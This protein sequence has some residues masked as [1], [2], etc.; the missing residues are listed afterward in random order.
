MAHLKKNTR[1]SLSGLSIH[2]ERKTDNH[3]NKEI[4]IS[5]SNLNQDLMQDNS[6]MV[7]RFNER[8]EDVYCMN[9]KDV[10]ALGTWVVTLPDELK[11]LSHDKQQ[12]FFNETKN[13]LDKRYGKENAVAA[14][15]HYDETTP[16]LHYGFV[17]V[18]YDEK[19]DRLKVSAKEVLNRK[20]LQTFHDDLNKHLK[21][22]L[23]F[24]EKGILNDQTLPF[25]NVEEIKK[26]NETYQEMKQALEQKKAVIRMKN[27]ALEP[28]EKSLKRINDTEK[29]FDTIDKNAKKGFGQV[30]IKSSDFEK[31]KTQAVENQVLAN[32]NE[33]EMYILKDKNKK[34]EKDN[35]M[36][37]TKLDHKTQKNESLTK[38]NNEL[39]KVKNDGHKFRELVKRDLEKQYNIVDLTEKEVNAL[40]V[41]KAIDED[42]K[43][44]NKEEGKSWLDDLNN[45]K[46]TRIEESMLEKAFEKA[47]ELYRE[48][49]QKVERM[50][51]MN[52]S[53]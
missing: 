27:D 37:S 10:K 12:E 30:V 23:P 21:E 47:L 14:I 18:V 6:N 45:G 16:H 1:A 38:K 31:L 22:K 20:D 7:E 52:I 36:L 46:G 3:S 4:D 25:Q 5:R 19:N 26:Y 43:P 13:F 32:A 8:L 40:S 11:D 50:M 24:Y 9:R 51:D 35:R 48:I 15:V 49:V 29:M 2:L 17:P 41:V 28:F 53:L 44:K 34:L 33:K 42:I 39:T